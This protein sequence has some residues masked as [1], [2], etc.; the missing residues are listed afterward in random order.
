MK[1]IFQSSEKTKYKPCW[2]N[3]YSHHGQSHSDPA[4][5]FQPPQSV[6]RGMAVGGG[7][8]PVVSSP[9]AAALDPDARRPVSGAVRESAGGGE[10]ECS[11]IPSGEGRGW[12]RRSAPALGCGGCEFS[13]DQRRGG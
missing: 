3:H 11:F 5:E 7:R 8:P 1:I 4:V 6:A 13:V 10:A 9:G 2:E 12:V